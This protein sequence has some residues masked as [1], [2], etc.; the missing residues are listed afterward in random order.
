[1][2][3]SVNC[4]FAASTGDKR[5]TAT[6]PLPMFLAILAVASLQAQAQE[7]FANQSA[8][9]SATQFRNVRGVGNMVCG[10]VNKP[11]EQGGYDGF[12]R[13]VYRDAHNWAV[14]RGPYYRFAENGQQKG[15]KF[16]Y[17]AAHQEETW[18]LAKASQLLQEANAA[19]DR[20]E[21]LFKACAAGAESAH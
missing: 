11:N 10:E 18:D 7:L 2:K 3:I 5:E 21:R 1:M 6:Y 15:T 12:A 9:P 13:F 8:N 17:D 14:E 4:S 16:M 19:T 20:V